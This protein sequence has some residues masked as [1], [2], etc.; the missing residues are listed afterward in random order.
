MSKKQG[1]HELSKLAKRR[2]LIEELHKEFAISPAEL[3]F[4]YVNR[5]ELTVEKVGDG[6]LIKFDARLYEMLMGMTDWLP[7][8]V[9]PLVHDCGAGVWFARLTEEQP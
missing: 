1:K 8:V 7:W 5:W 4:T 2:E 6:S 9:E 3:R